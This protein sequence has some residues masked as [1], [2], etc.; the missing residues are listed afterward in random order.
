MILLFL[1][2]CCS[3][4]RCNAIDN[5]LSRVRQNHFRWS[6]AVTTA[7]VIIMLAKIRFALETFR[8]QCYFSPR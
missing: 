7:G 3:R 2:C 1:R 5:A 6:R 4:A 8:S